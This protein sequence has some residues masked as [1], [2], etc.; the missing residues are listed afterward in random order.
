MSEMQTLDPDISP[1]E[2]EDTVRDIFADMSRQV[3]N[4]RIAS[5]KELKGID[6]SYIIDCVI[7]YELLSVQFKVL[8]ECK[9]L[10]RK[11]E[12]E[13]VQALHSK[14]LST[15][16]HKGIVVSANGFQSGAIE[17]AAVHGVALIEITPILL[18][19][20][21]DFRNRENVLMNLKLHLARE[22]TR[23]KFF[24]NSGVGLGT[25]ASP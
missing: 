6:G 14:V 9:L 3:E 16:A 20:K 1:G 4:F 13:D 22:Q 8:I 11:V 19:Q 2:F 7:E 24:K 5:R 23:R 15:G 17:F 18:R 12:R 25:L 10:S 21:S